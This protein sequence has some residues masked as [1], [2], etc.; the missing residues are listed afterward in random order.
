MRQQVKGHSC[1]IQHFVII[2]LH[3]QPCRNWH[4]NKMTVECHEAHQFC[5]LSDTRG[6]NLWPGA[7]RRQ[8][9]GFAE[10]T[11]VDHPLRP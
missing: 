11:V 5:D 3:R 4:S 9:G 8:D 1:L 10:A 2:R 6:I 7:C